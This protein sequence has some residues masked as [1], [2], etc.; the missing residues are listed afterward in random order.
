MSVFLQQGIQTR[1]ILYRWILSR[2]Q[3]LRIHTSRHFTYINI[4]KTPL[5]VSNTLFTRL[6]MY[7]S[8]KRSRK[9][10]MRKKVTISLTQTLPLIQ[11]M[12]YILP[13]E[14]NKQIKICA[15]YN[16][17]FHVTWSNC[18]GTQGRSSALTLTLM[19]CRNTPQVTV[20]KRWIDSENNPI[21][22]FLQL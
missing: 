12:W 1:P 16:S 8:K 5:L 17:T 21:F 9:L 6:E 20:N 10:A 22:T 18:L 2:T 4:H 15:M 11:Y 14:M 13:L 7:T 3:K 19:K